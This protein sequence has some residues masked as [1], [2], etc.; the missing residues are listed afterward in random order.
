VV[1]A[2][3]TPK[4]Q[5]LTP[6]APRKAAKKS[7]TPTVEVQQVSN[8]GWEKWMEW[9]HDLDSKNCI[10]VL[11]YKL[12]DSHGRWDEVLEAGKGGYISHFTFLK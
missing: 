9:D 10:A 8:L 12:R 4:P 6:F 11:I 7:D 2:P 3:G 5:S 1:P